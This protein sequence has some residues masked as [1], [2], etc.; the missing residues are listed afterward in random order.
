MNFVS[1]AKKDGEGGKK[2]DRDLYNVE[3]VEV[4]TRRKRLKI[5]FVGFSHDYTMNRVI[6][7][8]KVI[9]IYY[10]V[11]NLCGHYIAFLV[12]NFACKRCC[13]LM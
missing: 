3:I 8:M 2:T 9:S 6:T 1:S 12:S 4:D 7:I 11:Y 5:H 10:R 13:I